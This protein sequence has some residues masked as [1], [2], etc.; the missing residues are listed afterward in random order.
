MPASASC[1]A[2][3]DNEP[4]AAAG[5]WVIARLVRYPGEGDPGLAR[6]ERLLDPKRP[7]EMASEAA[8][9]RFGLPVEFSR[10]ALLEAQ[11]Y[12]HAV[13]PAETARR[14]D[15]RELP[16]V[17]I[18]GEDAKDFD[19]AVLAERLPSG[20][21]RLRVAIADVSHYVQPGSALDQDAIERGTLRVL[22]GRGYCDAAHGAIQS[23]LLARA[24]GGPPVHGGRHAALTPRCV[25]AVALLS[26]RDA[27]GGAPHLHPG[28]RGPV[29][30][31]RPPRASAW[32]RRWWRHC[33]RWWRCTSCCWR[34]AGA[35]RSRLRCAGDAFR[36][37]RRRAGALS[38]L[39]NAQR[40]PSAH[41]GMHDPRQCRRGS[42][43]AATACAL[44]AARARAAGREKAR[45][46]CVRHCAY[47]VS[48][49]RSP[50]R[51]M[52]R[53]LGA[54][55]P[56]VRDPLARP[57]VE[58]LVVRSL[59]QALY[60]SE[61]LGHFGLALKDYAHFTSPIRRY[62]D[63]MIHRALRAAIGAGPVDA[64]PAGEELAA[65]G[66]EMSRL[67]RRADEA[68]R[69]V[70]T[71][72]KCVYLRDR[73]GQSFDA[74]IT[75]VMEFGCLRAVARGG[76]GRAAAA[77]CAARRRV[78]HGSGWRSVA[79]SAHRSQ[80]G[81]RGATARHRRGGQAG[82][83][84]DRSGARQRCSQHRGLRPSM[85]CTR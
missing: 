58:S 16:L 83:G 55:A 48:S 10:E 38:A 77:G 75:T 21:F 71:F 13:D 79:R 24:A 47:W 11:R 80:A 46:S 53:D 73:I 39:C 5:D 78:P 29:S 18:D 28:P 7:V 23:P 81:T 19:D 57:F 65:A 3:G 1:A 31:V 35:R 17:T 32:A 9:A 42:G 15:L 72:L 51:C 49:W 36:I 70:S 40:C 45:T 27:L 20:G 2:V 74:L 50:I 56:R 76:R 64:L 6:I 30:S 25:G 37:R 62:P 84:A 44:A 54:V 33:C 8:I 43:A 52:P 63:L 60:Q 68:A 59:A 85:A 4:E 82:R 67:E 26:S 22:S 69:F 14:V 12:G 34:H 61:H 66:V 41:R